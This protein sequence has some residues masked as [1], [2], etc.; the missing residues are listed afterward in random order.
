MAS[1]VLTQGLFIG[2]DYWTPKIL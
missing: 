1:I 2:L